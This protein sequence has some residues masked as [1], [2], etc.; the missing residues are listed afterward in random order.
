MITKNKVIYL[1]IYLLSLVN[2]PLLAIETPNSIAAI[3]LTLP[4]D[5]TGVTQLMQNMSTA[6]I[7]E[8][9]F[10]ST[11]EMLNAVAN[12]VGKPFIAH[13]ISRAQRFHVNPLVEIYNSKFGDF[14]YL[15]SAMVQAI[16]A[17]DLRVIQ[18]VIPAYLDPNT[19]SVQGQ[20]S[21]I[22]IARY[23]NQGAI[24]DYLA[25]VGAK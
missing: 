11:G 15:R 14:N 17:G 4:D 3:I 9:A 5:Q 19:T 20:R 23:L 2:V 16:E 22:D 7:S 8:F 24:A 12:Q 6:G 1:S 21:L 18:G 13:S 10:T 25:A